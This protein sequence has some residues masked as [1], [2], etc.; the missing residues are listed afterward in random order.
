MKNFNLI[1]FLLILLIWGVYFYQVQPTVDDHKIVSFLIFL[2]IWSGL[3][4]V[5]DKLEARFSKE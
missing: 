2:A 3:S 5:I 1:K 4:I